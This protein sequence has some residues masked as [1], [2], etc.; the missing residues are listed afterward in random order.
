MSSESNLNT[1]TQAQVH[2]HGQLICVQVEKNLHKVTVLDY[3][4]S[5]ERSW[6]SNQKIGIILWGP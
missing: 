3:M 6:D 2:R 1:N 5:E 4:V